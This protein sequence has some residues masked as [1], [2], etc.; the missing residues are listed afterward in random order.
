M[1]QPSVEFSHTEAMHES[2]KKENSNK[3]KKLV[4]VPIEIINL[5][6]TIDDEIKKQT[7]QIW[8]DLNK[9]KIHMH[10]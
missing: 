9:F 3:L 6:K 10:A 2:K 8:Y 1:F 5:N 4:D 7:I